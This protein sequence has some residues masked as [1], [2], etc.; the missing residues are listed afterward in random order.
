MVLYSQIVGLVVT[1]AACVGLG[2]LYGGIGYSA[3]TVIGA[4]AVWIVSHRFALFRRCEPPRYNL[5]TRPLILAG[6]IAFV[7][8]WQT[9]DYWLSVLAVVAFLVF[10]PIIDGALFPAIAQLG[11]ARHRQEPEKYARR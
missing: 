11:V 8:E 7:I 4:V 1:I 9:P 5:V 2:A 3:G 6:V 10:A